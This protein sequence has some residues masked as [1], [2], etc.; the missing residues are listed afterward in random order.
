MNALYEKTVVLHMFVESKI[1]LLLSQVK[2]CD[3]YV[4]IYNLL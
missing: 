4:C 2:L 3:T 1:I